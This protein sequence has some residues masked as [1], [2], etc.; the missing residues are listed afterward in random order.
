[1]LVHLPLAVLVPLSGSLPV[2]VLLLLAP[3][4]LALPL[5]L[6]VPLPLALPF[7]FPFPLSFSLLVFLPLA[8]PLPFPLALPL[9]FA[10]AG[11]VC[12]PSSCT[13]HVPTSCAPGRPVPASTGHTLGVWVNRGAHSVGEGGGGAFGRETTEYRRQV[14]GAGSTVQYAAGSVTFT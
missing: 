5:A 14:V 8:R 9:Q 6:S 13:H 3:L 12:T 1:M 11:W 4:S 10:V 2:T 7:P